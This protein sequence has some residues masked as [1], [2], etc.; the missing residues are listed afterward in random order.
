[1]L[2]SICGAASQTMICSAGVN[3][4]CSCATM[5]SPTTVKYNMKGGGQCSAVL[6]QCSAAPTCP[7][8]R[9]PTDAPRI[10]T[11]PHALHTAGVLNNLKGGEQCSAVLVQC[12]AAPTCQAAVGCQMHSAS[13]MTPACSRKLRG[14]RQTILKRGGEQCSAV[15]VQC[16]AA[17]TCQAASLH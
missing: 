4:S 16:S 10:T 12:S 6:V 13:R 14:G 3:C 17:P 9:W 11:T 15:L 5:A 7:S 2:Y 1:M 8:K